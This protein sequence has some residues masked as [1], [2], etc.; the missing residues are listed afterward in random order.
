MKEKTDVEKGWKQFVKERRIRKE[1]MV[2][3]QFSGESLYKAFKE[4]YEQGVQDLKQ[5]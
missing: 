3:K 2:I 1:D 5:R 4:G